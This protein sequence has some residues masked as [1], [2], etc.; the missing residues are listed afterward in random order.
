MNKKRFYILLII[1]SGYG[2]IISA[3]SAINGHAEGSILLFFNMGG[4]F[5][6]AFVFM[7]FSGFGSPNPNLLN[8]YL[9]FVYVVGNLIAWSP[10][11][12]LISL[13]PFKRIFC[14]IRTR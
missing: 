14:L 12:F 3:I 7:L 11:A 4:E 9:G 5:A 2:T 10:I 8:V 6:S 13:I 1:L